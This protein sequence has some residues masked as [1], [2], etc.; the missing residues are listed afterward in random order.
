MDG[1]IAVIR[2]LTCEVASQNKGAS[3]TLREVS[4]LASL[5]ENDLENGVCLTSVVL[6]V[7]LLVRSLTQRCLRR[8]SARIL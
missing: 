8:E 5:Q 6:F 4:D 2:L 7:C 1:V 3:D